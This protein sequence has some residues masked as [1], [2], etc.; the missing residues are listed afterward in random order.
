[1]CRGAD[2]CGQGREQPAGL[3]GAACRQALLDA[4]A[5][6]HTGGG[7]VTVAHRQLIAN[8]GKGYRQV[9]QAEPF[10]KGDKQRT[11][12]GHTGDFVGVHAQPRLCRPQ[13]VEEF[14][15]PLA[16]G[17]ALGPEQIEIDDGL[18]VRLSTGRHRQREQAEKQG[19]PSQRRDDMP[20]CCHD[21]E[22]DVRRRKQTKDSA[23][24]AIA[25]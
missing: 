16:M 13:L 19:D 14:D 9:L 7:V 11:V 15:F 10:G 1:L 21:E 5:Q 20:P 12:L 18:A 6:Q 3:I 24:P 8:Y 17:T 4:P 22:R 23:P 2:R 25:H